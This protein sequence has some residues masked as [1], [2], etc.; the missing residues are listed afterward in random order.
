MLAIGHGFARMKKDQ[1]PAAPKAPPAPSEAGWDVT[2]PTFRVDLL[3]D[4][5]T[6]PLADGIASDQ[7]RVVGVDVVQTA[8]AGVG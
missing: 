1:C 5:E 3:R 8:C 7:H 2:V 6:D 4:I